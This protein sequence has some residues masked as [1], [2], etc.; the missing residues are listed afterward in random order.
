MMLLFFGCHTPDPPPVAARG[1]ILVPLD[2]ERLARRISIDLRGRLPD[3]AE[4]D[5]AD[6]PDGIPTL[7]DTWLADPAFESHLVDVFAES[8]L[9]RVDSLR[10]GPEEFGFDHEAD[11][12]E[13][14]RSI[15]DEPARLMAHIVATDQP[16][17]TIVTGDTTMANATLAQM[18]QLEW[19][20][21]DESKPWREARY[22]DGRPAGGVLMTSGLWLRYTTT[23]SNY[24]RGRAA[25]LARLL[26]CYD[27]LARPVLFSEVADNSTSGLL[28]AVNTDDGCISCHAALDPL[29][30][31]LF[32][33]WPFE[34]KDGAELANYHPEREH[35][36]LIATGREPAYFGVPVDA[37]AQLGPLVAED[38]RFEMCTVRRAAE[39]LWGRTTGA[40]DLS[41][42]LDLRTAFRDGN[43]RY[44]PLLRAILLSE[45]YQ[46]GDLTDEATD[47][48]GDT[49]HPLRLFTPDT[50]AAVLDDATGMRWTRDG[51][52]Q[53]DSDYSGYRVLLGGADGDTVRQSQLEPTL[54]R[55]LVIRRLAQRAAYAAVT[56][57][58]DASQADRRLFGTTVAL[59]A[60]LEPGTDA[61]DTEL[62]ALHRLLFAEAPTAE[63]L[64][65]ETQLYT[66]ALAVSTPEEAWISVVT[67]LLRDPDFWSY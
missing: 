60:D 11:A 64:T 49:L 18:V 48:E 52:D 14:T 24:N 44:K 35:Y 21:P 23:I 50:L 6:E 41:A 31:T 42:L 63:Q 43:G 36:G 53:L 57:D 12:F 5:T 16:W 33:F 28:A 22:T 17:S 26:L 4:L 19:V 45:E 61:F 25:A 13:Y 40:D 55:S 47:E 34:D 46:A 37:D 30:G 9:L 51:W 15:G 66:D 56:R 20:D 1:D 27:F 32:G 8:W 58:W 39:R 3:E 10:V 7:I 59:P 62:T 29:A 38:P 67:V 2:A 54:S 65:A